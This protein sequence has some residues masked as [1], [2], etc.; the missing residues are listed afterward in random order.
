MASG[1]EVMS[2]VVRALGWQFDASEQAETLELVIPSVPTRK[3]G[4][5]V[6]R[7]MGPTGEARRRAVSE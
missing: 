5:S 3:R 6:A 7:A 4:L 1:H 2:R